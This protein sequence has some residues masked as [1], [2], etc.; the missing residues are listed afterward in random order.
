MTSLLF[1]PVEG[2]GPYYV[3]LADAIAVAITEGKIAAGQKL[4]PQRNLAFDLGVTIGTIGRTY[5]LLHQRGLVSGEVGRGTYVA[6]PKSDPVRGSGQAPSFEFSGTRFHEP[7]EDKLRL[8]TTAAPDI[9]QSSIVGEVLAAITR[10]QPVAV[11]SYSRV[12]PQHWLDAGVSWLSRS[13]WR[14]TAD[15]IVPTL[16]AHAGAMAVIAAMSSPGDAVAFEA[17]T[18]SQFARSARL[19]G[20][21]ILPVGLDEEGMVPDEFE[22][23]CVE[24]RLK[25]AFLM[26][27]A[28]NPTL[29]IMSEER[30]RA[31]A[32]IARRHDVWLIED[33]IYGS[34]IGGETPLLAS[35]A[36]ERTFVVGSLSK[37][38]AA[39][40]RCGW[41]ACPEN[42]SSRIKITHKMITGGLSF[43]LAEAGARLVFSGAAEDIRDRVRQEIVAREAIARRALDGYDLV[44]RPTLPYLWLKLP[45]EWLSGTFKNA[46]LQ[47]GMLVDDEDEFKAGRIERVYHRARIGFS[48]ATREEMGNALFHLRRIIDAG[49]VGYDAEA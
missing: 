9:G 24:R 37:A 25:L 4:P 32:D 10:D 36:P 44:S 17:L 26:P 46:A 29:A 12:H 21:E 34:L 35:F 16:G 27:S 19:I 2:D 11:S 18:Y 14:P 22:R 8:D 5:T 7:P 48:S 38:V 40:I 15:T 6:P 31:L 3:R 33:D 42:F 1:Q 30:R 49:V 20:R 28:H 23:A 13:A 47:Q 41:V 45:G 39:G 43:V